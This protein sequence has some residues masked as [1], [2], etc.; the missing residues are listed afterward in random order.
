MHKVSFEVRNVSMVGIGDECFTPGCSYTRDLEEDVYERLVKLKDSGFVVFVS[1]M[2][3]SG[4]EASAPV[5]EPDPVVEPAPVEE[6]FNE[7]V[8]ESVPLEEAPIPIPPGVEEVVI[9]SAD[10]PAKTRKR[11]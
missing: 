10:A 4:E 7:P 1:D 5:V 2:F 11:K 9:Q 6:P 3:F 8:Q